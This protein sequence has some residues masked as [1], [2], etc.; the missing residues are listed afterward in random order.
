MKYQHAV[1][2]DSRVAYVYG[3]RFGAFL[4]KR[5]EELGLSQEDVA[6]RADIDRRHYQELEHGFSNSRTRTP[7]NPR[8]LTLIKLAGAL[9]M[10]VEDFFRNLG[11][12]LGLVPALHRY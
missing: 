8:L 5:R 1:A 10:D 6:L 9:D 12:A 11:S 3:R 7:A 2:I 4:R